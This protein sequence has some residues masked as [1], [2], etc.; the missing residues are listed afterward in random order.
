[1]LAAQLTHASGESFGS[2]R[3]CRC[4]PDCPAREAW[5]GVFP[6]Q[7]GVSRGYGCTDCCSTFT[8]REVYAVVL[9][10]AD[11]AALCRVEDELV[12]AGV[13]HVAFREPDLGG[14]LTA[15]GCRPMPD[16]KALPKRVRSLAL[17]GGA[18]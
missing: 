12:R 18:R 10:V 6:C 11:E 5:N 16:K 2:L 1:M 14:S 13:D 4:D 9:E 3:V 17:L 8:P 15:I 7:H